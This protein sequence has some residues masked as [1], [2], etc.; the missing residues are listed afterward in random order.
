[1]SNMADPKGNTIMLTTLG[2][3][4]GKSVA[5]MLVDDFKVKRALDEWLKSKPNIV[6]PS[7]N[8]IAQFTQNFLGPIFREI[9]EG[10]DATIKVRL[11]ALHTLLRTIDFEF[12]VK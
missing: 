2:D 3:Y 4:V 7:E 11:S 9:F 10:A 6:D 8:G 12:K 1:M 5:R